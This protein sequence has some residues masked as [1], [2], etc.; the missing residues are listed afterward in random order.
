MI[1]HNVDKTMLRARNVQI[2]QS[3]YPHHEREETQRVCGNGEK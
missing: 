1:R 3:N 2:T